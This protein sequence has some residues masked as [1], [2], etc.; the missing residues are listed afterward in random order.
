MNRGMQMGG[1]IRGESLRLI[2]KYETRDPFK[3]ARGLGVHVIYTDFTALK[4]M[5][6]VIKK[7][8][9]IIIN[10]NLNDRDR[11]TVCAHELGHDRLHR[12]FAKSADLLEFML[13]DMRSK[14]EYEAN[15]FAGELLIDDGDILTF[16][17]EGFDAYQIA[18]ELDEDINLILIK[19][20][21][22]RKRGYDL[23]TPYRPA[24]DFLK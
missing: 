11:R 13:Y 15:I 16:V 24:S 14:P 4:G 8:R 23:R 18:N 2:N 22:L 3:I 10:G 17:G 9:F 1:Y 7:S 6:K 20:D 19:A 21:E 12:H 5:Y